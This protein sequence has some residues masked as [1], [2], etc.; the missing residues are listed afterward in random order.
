MMMEERLEEGRREMEECE[1]V[2]RKVEDSLKEMER[3]R[4]EGQAGGEMGVSGNGGQSKAKELDDIHS[5]WQTIYKVD[6]D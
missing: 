1:R 6:D 5:L 3:L 2:R 4:R